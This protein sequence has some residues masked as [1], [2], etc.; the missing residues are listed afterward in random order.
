[1]GNNVV[2][3]QEQVQIKEK[4][5]HDRYDDFLLCQR[6]Y[7]FNDLKCRNYYLK[8]YEQC[9]KKLDNM[10]LQIQRT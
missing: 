10:K 5:C 3:T 4:K 8:K 9:I 7:G 2:I 1:M 6:E